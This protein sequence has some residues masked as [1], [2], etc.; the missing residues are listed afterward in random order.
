MKTDELMTVEEVAA[1]L[2]I[3]RAGVYYAISKGRLE[4]VQ[5]FG[6]RLILR[7]SVQAYKPLRSDAGRKRGEPGGRPKEREE[8]TT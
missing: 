3:H 1:A 8:E 2:G 5:A 4:T 6:K 7:K